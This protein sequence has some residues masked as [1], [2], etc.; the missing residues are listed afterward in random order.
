MSKKITRRDFLDGVALTV[1][2]SLL[3]A[4]GSRADNSTS[5][6][7]G[8]R[9][10]YPPAL[11]GMRGSHP[12]SFEVAHALAWRGEKP[13]SYRALDEH[14]DLVI[15]GSGM[16]GLASAWYYRQLVGAS[17]K[18]L[19]LDNHDDFGGHAKR[20]EFHY[21]DKMVLSIGGA[22]NI[23]GV[24]DYSANARALLDGIGV[25]EAFLGKMRASTPA[26]MALS[27]N[28]SAN[29]GISLPDGETHTTVVGPWLM[30]LL[31]AEGYREAI[32]NL[33]IPELEHDKLIDFVGGEKDFLD[34]LSLS[35]KYDYI[36]TV[37]YNAYLTDRVGLSR[38][39][40]AILDASK[41]IYYGHTG[42]HLTVLEALEGGAPG[43]RSLGWLGRV[44]SSTI[45][46]LPG[47]MN[48]DVRMFPDGNASIA[49][50]LVHSL[51]PGSALQMRG[52]E[53]VATARFDYAA[54]DRPENRIRLRLNSTVVGVKEEQIGRVKV[55]YVTRGHPL[56]VTANHCILA[57]YN[58]LIP[59]LCP[60]LPEQQ[61]AAL[62]Y[63]VK[64][65][66]VYA[67]VL[68]RN[69]R[70]FSK[71]NA[72]LIQCPADPFQWVS[73]APSMQTAGYEPPRG[74]NDP[75]AVFMMAAPT[76]SPQAGEPLRD[77]LRAGRHIIYATP[78]ERFEADIRKQLQ[79]LLGPFGFDNEQ[80]IVAITVNRI[81]HGYAY[82]YLTLEDPRWQEGQAPNELG[83]ARF[84]HI[85]IANS[86]AEA[87]AYMD[88][89][90]DAAWRAVHEQ[91]AQTS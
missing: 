39:S 57:C 32:K 12:G 55:D 51:I 8:H 6:A 46:T 48:S 63:G 37:S 11:N 66:F 59:H 52:P 62:R 69:S 88:A 89:A 35:E 23:E 54:L 86:D 53:D 84:G 60:E 44:A 82:E 17:A 40:L 27:G 91:T 38:Q 24:Q 21:Q 1:G 64:I 79:A 28:F 26:D 47:V 2:A 3:P 19:L 18:I 83:R 81:P 77:L 76:P 72:T 65:P 78:F 7:E 74:P 33:P 4:A 49:R 20:N 56:S 87:R 15:V 58:G 36:R 67:N 42:W 85:S 34:D 43:L 31:G 9:P 22:Q 14:Y 70:A 16:S 75:M 90:F 71:L 50:L 45:L 68:L 73:A 30:F 80:D 29:T 5:S 41:R 25:D 61:K 13:S 10:D